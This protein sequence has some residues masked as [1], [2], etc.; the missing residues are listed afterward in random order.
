MVFVGLVI[1]ALLAIPLS[2]LPGILGAVFPFI[3]VLLFGY[4]GVAIFISRRNDIF[5]IFGGRVFTMSDRG[6]KGADPER[7]ILVDTSVIIDGRIADI[8]QTGFLVGE[9]LIP[10]FVLD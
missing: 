10:R 3:G 8:A 5:S 9:L 6:G 4:I 2:R 1:A 7:V